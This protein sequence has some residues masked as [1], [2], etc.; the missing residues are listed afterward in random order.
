MNFNKKEDFSK[1]GVEFQQALGQVLQ[2][3]RAFCDQLG[4]ILKDEFFDIQYIG[5]FVKEIY[6]YKEKYR[7]HPSPAIMKTII[8][9]KY[10]D[11]SDLMNA[12][13]H[14]YYK[15]F[16][17]DIKPTRETADYVKEKALDF[18][19]K[20]NLKIAFIKSGE[21]QKDCD[22]DQ[23]KK[24]IDDSLKMGSDND[25]GHDYLIDFEKRFEEGH[26]LVV[27]TPYEEINK[28][29]NGGHGRGELGI[30]MA[31]S[32][33]GK[34]SVLTHIGAWSIQNDY[35]VVHY[36]LELKDTVVA[37]KYDSCIAQ[38]E[39]NDVI[40]SK[41]KVYNSIKDF[42]S[43][44]IIKEYPPGY[45][46]VNHLRNHLERLK[47][48]DILPD[49]VIVDYGDLLTTTNSRGEVRH[50][51]GAIFESLRGLAMEF[52]VALWTATQTNRTGSDAPVVTVE[53]ISEAYSKIFCADFVIGLA[54]TL[55]DR[56]NGSGRFTIGKNRNGPTGDIFP[57]LMNLG[58]M[59]IEVLAPSDETKYE[60]EDR[61]K[62]QQK[63]AVNKG[64][65]ELYKK[66][67]EQ[68]KGDV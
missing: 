2:D 30:I 16:I 46:T 1:L 11:K 32:G 14:Q 37:Q 56:Q 33:I 65:A 62:K 49:I 44:L 27:P 61:V 53:M 6:N 35:N 9:D 21:M 51:Q 24:V 13:V 17:Q 60:I 28:V 47:T 26:R 40:H 39:L 54:R 66:F 43:K 45:A 36:T 18:C 34:S 50:D 68:M 29:M 59:H 12:K 64:V 42:Q 67:Q 20:Q 23:I 57:I 58:K 8:N 38:I 22:F 10:G 52:N 4:E 55:S 25:F 3:D 48:N 15:E 7:F 19:K 31:P 5:L 63:V 41:E